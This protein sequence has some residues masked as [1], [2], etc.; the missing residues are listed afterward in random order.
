MAMVMMRS[1]IMSS[2]MVKPSSERASPKRVPS[3]RRTALMP[4]Y[5]IATLG[6]EVTTGGTQ[7]RVTGPMGAFCAPDLGGR[8]HRSGPGPLREGE[9]GRGDL[10]PV[11]GGPAPGRPDLGEPGVVLD[12]EV[13]T[14]V[15]VEGVDED[16]P[17]PGRLAAVAGQAGVGGV[18]DPV[19]AGPVGPVPGVDGVG[20][21][22]IGPQLGGVPARV[23]GGVGEVERRVGVGP[24]EQED[25]DYSP[26]LRPG[27]HV[28]VPRPGHVVV[29]DVDARVER[30]R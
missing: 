11:G 23:D 30:H 2:M 8:A 14:T 19:E 18:E 20:P 28:D 25:L 5:R 24:G 21:R 12:A 4:A 17:H 10:G 9:L 15:A 1:A 27:G 26:V 29:A 7:T 22:D 6:V 13:W 16:G 3:R